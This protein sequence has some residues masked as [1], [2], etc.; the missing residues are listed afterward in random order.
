MMRYAITDIETTGGQPTGNSITEIAVIISDGER[1]IDRFH[2]LIRPDHRIPLHIE[3]LTGI[4]NEMV[5]DAPP[6]SE[7][8]KDLLQF[9]EG[10]VFVAHNV[11]F[12]YSFLKKA[13]KS[14]DLAFI[15]V[16]LC[17]VRIARKLHP[18]LPSYSLGRLCHHFGID[19]THAH[20]AL[21]DT[22]VTATLFHRFVKEDQTGLIRSMLASRSIDQWLPPLLP[23]ED[24]ETLPEKPGVYYFRNAEGQCLYIGKSGNV[25]KRV[26]QHFGGPMQT[27]KRQSFLREITSID[28]EATGSETIAALL[29]DAE[30]RAHWPTYN[31]AQKRKPKHF[32][33][34]VYEDQLGY[35]RLAIQE[36]LTPDGLKRFTSALAARDWLLRAAM[37]FEI[38]LPLC[39]L[40][41][42]CASL[43]SVV[44]ANNAVAQLQAA[45]RPDGRIT[46]IIDEGRTKCEQSFIALRDEELLGYGYLDKEERVSCFEDLESRLLRLSTS[47]L[48]PSIVRHALEQCRQPVV[49]YE[50]EEAP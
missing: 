40:T 20:R 11:G 42:G 31:R 10:A 32:T 45:C 3:R 26:R 22:L 38:P 50:H 49:W 30:I 35:Q 13:F 4:D 44:T 41:A 16:R 21:N 46:V 27:A 29:E 15:P 39:G 48:T 1:E 23:P 18:Q 36:G 9:L 43:P 12:D 34:R 14:C 25:K 47:E 5:A 28:V 37:Q 19:H 7:I 8:A 17:T 33:V 2:S 6:F 24:F